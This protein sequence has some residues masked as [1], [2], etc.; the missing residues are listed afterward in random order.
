ML[1]EEIFQRQKEFEQ[2]F[3][4]SAFIDPVYVME[5]C[6]WLKPEQIV[7]TGV[8]KFWEKLLAGRSNMEASYDADLQPEILKWVNR[9][10]SSLYAKEYAN[11]IVDQE[12]LAK[13][14][15]GMSE[16]VKATAD[17]DIEKVHTL[18]EELAGQRVRRQEKLPTAEQ[19][20]LE[21]IEAVSSEVRSITTGIPGLDN[22]V[23]GLE[24]QTLSVL[25]ARPSMGK[26]SLG[27]Q[28][29]RNVV[30][31]GG[32][33]VIFF[34]LEMNR[35]NLWARAACGM[36][37]L[38]WLDLRAGKITDEEHAKVM[39]END[40][41]I[42]RYGDR[43]IIDHDMTDTDRVW[44]VVSSEKP[45]LVIIDHLRLLKDKHDSEVKRQGMIT[46]RLHDLSKVADCHIMALAQLNRGVESRSDRRPMLSDLR[47]SGEIEENSDLVF[48]LYRDD[49]Y[50][51]TEYSR[52]SDTELLIRK[53]RDGIRDARLWL[54]FDTKRQW[55]D[56]IPGEK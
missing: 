49:Y 4:A 20:G 13:V 52:Y 35:V 29:A 41:L 46:E 30:S 25:A 3:A 50:N 33:K 28:I 19:A 18:L 56:P 55:F 36:A 24:R 23:G 10:P 48:M 22:N 54:R 53:F 45:D 7:D 12:Y 38:S 17:K 8:R 2:L 44:Q 5:T 32:M 21:F 1:T 51:A 15:V 39:Q 40:K 9:T 26:S 37:G 14:S 43:L 42:Q 11:L 6:G 31:P 27:F 47:D 16:L 34:S